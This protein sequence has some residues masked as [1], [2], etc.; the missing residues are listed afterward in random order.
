MRAL[1]ITHADDGGSGVFADAAI[2]AGWELD[3]WRIF[4]EPEPPAEPLG[5]GAVLSFGGAMNTHE[6]ELF[7]WLEDERRRLTSLHE[8]GVPLLG[9][10]L[11]AQLVSEAAGG[12]PGRSADPEIGWYEVELCDPGREDPLLGGMPASF[13]AFE[14]HSYECRPPTGAVTLARS[15]ACIQA[16]RIG[17][18]TYGIQFHAEVTA[19]DVAAWLDQYETD[20]DAIR[21]GVDPGVLGPENE[22]RMPAWNELG[23]GFCRRFLDLAAA[24]RDVRAQSG[25]M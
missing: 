1:A 6:K 3:V 8:A 16:Y 14:W 17:S 23:R 10:C 15:P 20:P 4:A 13:E 19:S 2:E 24:S 12:S 22:R 25:V 7:P 9:V 18:T 5:Y 11:G 21:L